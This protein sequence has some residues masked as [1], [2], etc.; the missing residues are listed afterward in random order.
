MVGWGGKITV[1]K[2]QNIEIHWSSNFPVSQTVCHAALR[3]VLEHWPIT[4]DC[5]GSASV[6][7]FHC[8][9]CEQ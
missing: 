3:L 9:V 6:E 5:I 1:C 2:L 8:D 4:Q 7:V